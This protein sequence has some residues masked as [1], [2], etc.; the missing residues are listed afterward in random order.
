MEPTR[1]NRSFPAWAAFSYLRHLR[2]WDLTSNSKDSQLS[3]SDERLSTPTRSYGPGFPSERNLSWIIKLIFPWRILW[4]DAPLTRQSRAALE[5][6]NCI[7]G[8]LRFLK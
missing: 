6:H 2:I 1:R 3:M 5:R 7:T 8:A 4:L